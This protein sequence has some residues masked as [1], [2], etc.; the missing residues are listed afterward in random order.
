MEDLLSQD[1]FLD[2]KISVR[3]PKRGFRFTIDAPLLA[4]FIPPDPGRR[5]LEIGSG[6]GIISLILARSRATEFIVALEIQRIMV[7]ALRRNV[8]ENRLTER[9]FPLLGD[10]RTPPL[11][12]LFDGIFA[13][14]PY[15]RLGEGKVSSDPGEA[16]ARFEL[17]LDAPTL[18]QNAAGLL[19]PQGRLWLIYP[20]R[21]G[22]EI[23]ETALS[24][25]LHPRR[26]RLILRSPSHPHPL[27]SLWE[28]SLQEGSCLKEKVI[29]HEDDG[30]YT[31]EVEAVLRGKGVS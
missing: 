26:K 2:G 11:R 16:A 1:R 22:E 21:R 20:A 30:R 24:K 18:L 17:L 7:E 5:L 3:Q 13:N 29:L 19:L 28:F 14:P 10:F 4:D 31:P 27:F 9:V 6:C 12:P 8:Q 15:G 23:K 25:G